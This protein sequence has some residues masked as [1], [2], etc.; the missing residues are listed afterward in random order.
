MPSLT[1]VRTEGIRRT[2]LTGLDSSG[3]IEPTPLRTMASVM[4]AVAKFQRNPR[5][6]S[7]GGG[8]LCNRSPAYVWGRIPSNIEDVGN[9][10]GLGG[11]TSKRRSDQELACE[12]MAT[13]GQRRGSTTMPRPVGRKCSGE[14]IQATPGKMLL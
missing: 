9:A 7:E 11:S 3:I 13:E 10:T 4:H 1:A 12:S 14:W 2:E 5:V 8:S 6:E